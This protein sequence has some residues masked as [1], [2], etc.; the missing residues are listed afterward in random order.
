MGFGKFRLIAVPAALLAGLHSFAAPVPIPRGGAAKPSLAS[1]LNQIREQVLARQ[2]E[3][4]A[5]SR[6]QD[7]ARVQVRKIQSLL[8]LQKLERQVAAQRMNELEHTVGELESRR[9]LLGE[10]IALRKEQVRSRLRSLGLGL[11]DGERVDEKSVFIDEREGWDSI[12]RKVQA[13]IAMSS[14]RE[15]EEFRVDLDDARA[16]E[17]QIQEERQQLTLLFE[18][19]EEQQGVLELNQQLQMD[20][21][22]RGH[23]SRMAQLE[24]YRRLKEAE[25]SVTRMLGEFNARRELQKQVDDERA[26]AR[27]ARALQESLFGR[28]QG[29]LPLPVKGSVVGQF[30]RSLDPGSRLM[31]FKKGIEIQASPGAPVAAVATGRVAFAGVLP[32]YGKVL[33]LDHGDH[34]Y[35]LSAHLNDLT[36]KTGDAVEAGDLVGHADTSGHPVYFEIRSRNI[37]VNPL[38]WVASSISLNP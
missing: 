31:V 3:L 36:R 20:I 30:G 11:I 4:I 26:R 27:V 25:A 10:K 21:I 14:V 29:S 34:Y 37:A 33:I 2:Q 13:G 5:S 1:R 23:H 12:A 32:N 28:R 8:G 9:N 24:N 19:I 15:I 7:N 18:D 38:Q 22:R 16:L 35:T 17:R 6:N